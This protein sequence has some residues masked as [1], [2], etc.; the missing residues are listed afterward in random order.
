[1]LRQSALQ[2][3]RAARHVAVLAAVALVA[4]VAPVVVAAAAVLVAAAVLANSCS[5]SGDASLGA[6]AAQVAS[7]AEH[8]ARREGFLQPCDGVGHVGRNV[9]HHLV[10]KKKRVGIEDDRG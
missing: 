4:A 5:T 6:G 7:V 10:K 8:H 1:L 2:A 9:K 3:S